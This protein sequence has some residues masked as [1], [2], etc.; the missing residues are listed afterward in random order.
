[1]VSTPKYGL[2]KLYFFRFFLLSFFF[3]SLPPSLSLSPS[4]STLLVC[5]AF[6][7]F[8]LL[9]LKLVF[10]FFFLVSGSSI[11]WMMSTAGS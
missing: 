11:M 6:C 2:F 3:L 10:H 5:F 8:S 1:M 7:V 4:L 9:F